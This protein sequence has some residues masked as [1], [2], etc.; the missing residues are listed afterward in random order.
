MGKGTWLQ[1]ATD[2][3]ENMSGDVFAG[4]PVRLNGGHASLA[5]CTRSVDK[6]RK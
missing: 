3:R 2:I 4:A 1:R 6:T 5:K